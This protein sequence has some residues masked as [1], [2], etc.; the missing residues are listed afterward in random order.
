MK[1]RDMKKSALDLE[2]IIQKLK[3]QYKENVFKYERE[4]PVEER[5]ATIINILDK[6]VNIF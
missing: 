5:R 2:K 6:M 4:I 3:A 1:V